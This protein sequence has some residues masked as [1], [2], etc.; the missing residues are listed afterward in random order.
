M[1][2]NWG[3]V[4]AA[5]GLAAFVLAAYWR[6]LVRL[7]R[8]LSALAARADAPRAR[9]KDRTTTEP[10][11]GAA[12]GLGGSGSIDR[13]AERIR[14]AAGSGHPRGEPASRPPGQ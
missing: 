7:D 3:Y 6:H 4:F 13:E 14:A 5:Y 10:T 8:A 1:P 9:T 12:A 2:D 11:A